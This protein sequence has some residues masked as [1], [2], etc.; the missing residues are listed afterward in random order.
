[1]HQINKYGYTQIKEFK[2]K[3]YTNKH[4]HAFRNKQLSVSLLKIIII[5][6]I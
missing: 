4:V 3:K 1:M 5:K 2:H 6:G